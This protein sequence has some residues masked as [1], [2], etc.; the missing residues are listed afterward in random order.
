MEQLLETAQSLRE[1]CADIIN[2]IQQ[3]KLDTKQIEYYWHELEIGDYSLMSALHQAWQEAKSNE[4]LDNF[5]EW[6]SQA[7]EK[8]YTTKTPTNTG[9]T[10]Q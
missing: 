3:N 8:R 5:T 4:Q 10:A 6:H 1:L 2:Q 7:I 9:E